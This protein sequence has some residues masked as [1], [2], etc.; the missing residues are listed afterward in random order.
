VGASLAWDI[1]S[2]EMF[3]TSLQVSKSEIDAYIKRL[4]TNKNRPHLH[5]AEIFVAVDSPMDEHKARKKINEVLRYLNQGA[6]FSVLAQQF[7]ESPTKTQGGNIGWIPEGELDSEIRSPVIQLS[8]NDYTSPIKTKEGYKILYLIDRKETSPEIAAQTIYT[9]KRI[10]FPVSAMASQQKLMEVF[11]KAASVHANARSCEMLEK[12]AK[13][14]GNA[15]IKEV[16]GV[17]ASDLPPPVLGILSK[18][19]ACK[20]GN[21]PSKCKS[22]P[23]I[24]SDIGVLMFM[25][26]KQEKIA[27]GKIDRKNIENR[28]ANMKLQKLMGREMRNLR[29]AAH[30]VN[31]L[32]D[33]VSMKI[34]SR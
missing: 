31:K 34:A 20:I 3:R 17:S 26:C 32:E 9:Y 10:N 12:L 18:L 23:P 16:G 4:E 14:A 2:R 11:Q 27:A 15:Q 25:V 28:I 1:I 33:T 19:D 6:H 30:V 8:T 13:T 24:R 5:L 7:S 29:R 22:S 21:K